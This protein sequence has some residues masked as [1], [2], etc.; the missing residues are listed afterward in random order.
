MMNGL[1]KRSTESRS[2]GVVVDARLW[3]TAMEGDNAQLRGEATCKFWMM[4]KAG[5]T[6]TYIP[7]ATHTEEEKG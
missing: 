2:S 4:I 7:R 3:L 6:T 1:S 5:Q